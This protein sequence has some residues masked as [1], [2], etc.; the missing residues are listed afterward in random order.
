[1]SRRNGAV[2]AFNPER[3]RGDREGEEE[4]RGKR[5]Y[6][7]LFGGPVVS[8]GEPVDGGYPSTPAVA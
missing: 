3:L 6:G 5:E 8:A 1:V 7:F 2:A 4:E